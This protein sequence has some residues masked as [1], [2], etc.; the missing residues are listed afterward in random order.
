MAAWADLKIHFH[1]EE[2]IAENIDFGKMLGNDYE[3]I[4]TVPLGGNKMARYLWGHDIGGP[5]YLEFYSS[6]KNWDIMVARYRGIRYSKAGF[7]AIAKR[8]MLLMPKQWMMK[9]KT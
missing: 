7:I 8:E 2:M 6:S 9:A 3:I 1:D 5:R 4:N